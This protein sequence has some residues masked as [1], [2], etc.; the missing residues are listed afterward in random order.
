[1]TWLSGLYT[2]SRCSPNSHRIIQI[3]QQCGKTLQKT[4]SLEG[5]RHPFIANLMMGTVGLTM[6][7][8]NILS[9][10][11]WNI[12]CYALTFFLLLPIRQT[13]SETFWNHHFK[14]LVLIE[15]MDYKLTSKD[16]GKGAVF[17][18]IGYRTRKLFQKKLCKETRCPPKEKRGGHN[19]TQGQNR[20]PSRGSA[21]FSTA[22]QW[23]LHTMV[24]WITDLFI[25]SLQT[26]VAKLK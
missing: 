5:L 24:P 2:L 11:F 9:S 22:L 21:I 19:R 8:W 6:L 7:H 26:R 13:S 1:M 10:T 14:H 25:W 17:I 20:W 12:W 18:L 16:Q 23:I 3:P 15:F 4:P